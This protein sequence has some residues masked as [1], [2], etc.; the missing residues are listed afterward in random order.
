[1]DRAAKLAS[2]LSARMAMRLNSLSLQKKF[3]MSHLYISASSGSG[4]GPARM[5]GDN[6]LGAALV[7]VGDDGVAVEGLVGDQRTERDAVDQRRHADRVEA[8]AG[9]QDKTDQIAE[10][11]GEGEYLGGHA[12]LGAAYGLALRSE[13]RRVGKECR[14]W[15]GGCSVGGWWA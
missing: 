11:V 1:M 12:A 4:A 6:D 3:S 9:Q 2:V 5:L 10:R 14:A 15:G 7:E 13:E 8:M